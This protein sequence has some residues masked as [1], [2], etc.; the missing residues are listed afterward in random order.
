MG[1]LCLVE[2]GLGGVGVREGVGVCKA[3][4]VAP[5]AGLPLPLGVRVALAEPAGALGESAAVMLG[6]EEVEG[7]RG[8]PLGVRCELGDCWGD[9][10]GD[11]VPCAMEGV[12]AEEGVR[13]PPRLGVCRAEDEAV[14]VDWRVVVGRDVTVEPSLREGEGEGVGEREAVNVPC[15]EAVPP[16]APPLA[17]PHWEAEG[18]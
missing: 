9:C 11:C 4:G 5:T 16:A 14:E 2:V 6:Q 7:K 15:A 18:D 3:V 1:V 12:A 17:L 8:V 10:V 13:P